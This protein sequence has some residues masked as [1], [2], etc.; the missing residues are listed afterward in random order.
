MGQSNG[1]A[2][3][4][5]FFFTAIAIWQFQ[6]IATAFATIASHIS[7][8]G[9][10]LFSIAAIS[11]A[12][13]ILRHK[14]ESRFAAKVKQA[15]VLRRFTKID[16]KT[17]VKYVIPIAISSVNPQPLLSKALFPF[18]SSKTSWPITVIELQLDRSGS[19]TITKWKLTLDE[20]DLIADRDRRNPRVNARIELSPTVE[21][22]YAVVNRIKD[23]NRDI[24]ELDRLIE[25]TQN[26]EAY[27]AERKIYSELKG[28]LVEAL[29]TSEKVIYQARR[30]ISETLVRAEVLSSRFSAFGL[31]DVSEQIVEMQLQLKAV[32]DEYQALREETEAY[33]QLKNEYESLE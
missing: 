13:G 4:L 30:L 18:M 14:S 12:A 7:S 21:Q 28:R 11:S 26:S 31:P 20:I 22:M 33:L 19:A 15:P 9:H 23:I 3:V 29:R 16:G 27:A 17:R 32:R 8:F 10:Y 6:S 2:S 5:I 25:L 24:G 1:C